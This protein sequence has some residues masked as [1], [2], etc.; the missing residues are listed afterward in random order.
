[1]RWVSLIPKLIQ[2]PD[3]VHLCMSINTPLSSFWTSPDSKTMDQGQ[4]LITPNICQ[5]PESVSGSWTQVCDRVEA[6]RVLMCLRGGEG[7]SVCIQMSERMDRNV[8]ITC[9]GADDNNKENRVRFGKLFGITYQY[10][11]L[12][13]IYFW[14]FGAFSAAQAFSSCGEGAA[15]S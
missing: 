2:G 7:M 11:L 1:M 13:R 14:L 4:R 10:F 8:R 3:H 12:F 15:L 6:K 9:A 5:G